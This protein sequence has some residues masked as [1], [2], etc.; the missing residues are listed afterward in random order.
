MSTEEERAVLSDEEK[1]LRDEWK[2]YGVLRPL[3]RDIIPLFEEAV[4]VSCYDKRYY[5]KWYRN[6]AEMAAR[7]QKREVAQLYSMSGAGFPL[8]VAP[9]SP[10]HN[11]C[12]HRPMMESS[13]GLAAR[14]GCRHAAILGHYP[15]VA[16]EAHGIGLL[17]NVAL[18]VGG[19]KWLVAQGMKA[20]LLF[21]LNDSEDAPYDP[22]HLRANEFEAWCRT[23]YPEFATHCNPEISR[24]V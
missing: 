16:G 5:S 2:D 19:K 11:S 17:Q 24:S 15:C 8:V 21:D 3:D 7:Q 4:I 22:W 18:L 10:I 12:D 13:V 14:T 23:R 6:I 1:R 9:C 20:V